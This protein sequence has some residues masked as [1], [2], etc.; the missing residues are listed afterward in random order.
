MGHFGDV[1]ALVNIAISNTD[2]QP[3]EIAVRC[4]IALRNL[5]LWQFV[6]SLC[7]LLR[8]NIINNNSSGD[9]IANAVRPRKLPEFA[10]ITQNN[11]HYAVQGHS[12]SPIL[13]YF[14]TNR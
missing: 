14:G 12:R 9:E 13:P 11:G 6:F 7:G 3:T 8:H 4:H 5:R 10:E 1:V 2:I